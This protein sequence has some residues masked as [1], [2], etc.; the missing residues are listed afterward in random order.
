MLVESCSLLFKNFGHLDNETGFY[1]FSN[2]LFHYLLPFLSP[3]LSPSLCIPLLQPLSRLPLSL[4]LPPSLPSSLPSPTP[5]EYHVLKS[6]KRNT[7]SVDPWQ[8]ESRGHILSP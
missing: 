3:S 6:I 7:Y 1:S 5:V 2:F 4:F 8:Y